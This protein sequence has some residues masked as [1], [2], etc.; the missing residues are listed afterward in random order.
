M[1]PGVGFV[2]LFCLELI[3]L[4][5]TVVYSLHQIWKIWDSSYMCVSLIIFPQIPEAPLIFLSAFFFLCFCLNSFFSF[6]VGKIVTE[7][8]SVPI[9]LCF[10]WDAAIAWLDERC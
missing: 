4:L 3:E 8:T 2:C 10:I 9:F 5:G 1:C 6:L 7:L